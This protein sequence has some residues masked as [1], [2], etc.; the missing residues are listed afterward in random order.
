ATADEAGVPRPWRPLLR[1]VLVQLV[2]N[3][4]AHGIEPID[5]RLRRGKPTEG[6]VQ[7]ALRHH[8]DSGW[9]EL[10]V[11]DDG[12]GLDAEKVRQRAAELGVGDAGGERW[13][14]LLFQPGF[15]TVERP[16]LHAG[17]GVG[18]DAVRE[19]VDA[20]GGRVELHS[21]RGNFCAVQVLLP[22]PAPVMSPAVE[23][24]A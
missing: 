15:T 3:A 18:L 24:P 2:R 17:R 11:Q 6:L 9:L 23:V 14:E 16:H 5:E 12:R 22:L 21:E 10:I 13:A 1:D 4:V 7:L 8:A 19:L 20:R